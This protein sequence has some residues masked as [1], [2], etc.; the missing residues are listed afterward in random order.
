[1]VSRKTGAL[2]DASL[3]LGALAAG[4]PFPAVDAM[5]RCGRSLGIAFQ[6]RDDALGVWGDESRTGKTSGTDIRHRKKS[7]PVVFALAHAD[8]G[9]REQLVRIYGREDIGEEAVAWVLAAMDSLGAQGYCSEVA[10][11]H[12]DAALHHLDSAGL[13][14]RVEELRETAKFL[15]VRDY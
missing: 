9:Q 7:L 6:V 15:L 2:F 4:A 13:K 1:M 8:A 11:V 3:A 5:G 12:Y 14:T 10:R